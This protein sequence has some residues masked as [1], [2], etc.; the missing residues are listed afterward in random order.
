MSSDTQ[1]LAVYSDRAADYADLVVDAEQNKMLT[2][3][4]G[5]MPKGAQVLDLGCGP[6]QAAAAM[7]RAGLQADAWDA[8]AKMVQ[9]ARQHQGVDSQ[10]KS[11]DDLDAD[12]QYHGI[13]ASFSLL[14]AP[15]SSFPAHLKA[16]H[17]ALAPG[18]LLVLAM[19]LGQGEIRDRIG[20]FYAYYSQSELENHLSQAGFTPGDHVLGESKGLSGDVAPFIV[21]SARA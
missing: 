20:R 2:K 13:W 1:T 14:H 15:K 8:T 21:I 3:F 4:M 6:G 9:L 7:Q 18:G 17:R 5:A 19:K 16:I 10:L 12:H 11:F